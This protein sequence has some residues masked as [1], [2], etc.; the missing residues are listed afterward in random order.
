MANVAL[1]DVTEVFLVTDELIRHSDNFSQL[2]FVAGDA[3]NV[4]LFA[5]QFGGAGCGHYLVGYEVVVMPC[6]LP[7]PII[8]LTTL[9]INAL[10]I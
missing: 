9:R 1:R 5:F 3:I 6:R 4:K 2:G 7:S 8:L 10:A